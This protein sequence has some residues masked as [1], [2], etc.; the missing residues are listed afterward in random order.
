[1]KKQKIRRTFH[2]LLRKTPM[3]LVTNQNG[4]NLKLK[5]VFKINIHGNGG[6][7]YNGNNRNKC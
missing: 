5:N 7:S 3:C 6:K 2:V 1:M 4:N